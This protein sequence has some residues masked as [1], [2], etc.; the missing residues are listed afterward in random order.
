M[1]L[2]QIARKISI[3]QSDV[4]DLL[5][6]SGISIANESNARLENEHV[7]VIL[8]HFAPS[9]LEEKIEEVDVIP[10]QATEESEVIEDVNTIEEPIENVVA[11][12]IITTAPEE[13][14]EEKVELIKAPKVDLPGLKVIGKIDLPEP[15]KKEVLPADESEKAEV[16]AVSN[17]ETNPKPRP[18]RSRNVQDSRR[19]RTNR[20]SVNPI[21]LQREREARAAEE[22][23][24]TDAIKEK[25][26]RTEYY[27]N[28][29]KTNVTTKAS[30]IYSEPVEEYTAHKKKEAPKTLLGK[31][32]RWLRSE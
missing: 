13:Q 26:K 1:R 7:H 24:K 29:L 27:L 17:S 14:E 32:F 16:A 15:K 30:R 21:A 31:F 10:P 9:F 4:V 25:E 19:E 11:E 20:S 28:R 18:Q 5:A 3:R 23:R 12:I 6:K 2:G 8:Q 22:K